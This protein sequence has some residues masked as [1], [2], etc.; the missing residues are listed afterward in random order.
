[1][2]KTTE[3]NKA[4]IIINSNK[5]RIEKPPELFKYKMRMRNEIHDELKKK[6]LSI[7]TDSRKSRVN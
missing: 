2:I 5:D 6:I 1:L 4:K 3:Y 7:K